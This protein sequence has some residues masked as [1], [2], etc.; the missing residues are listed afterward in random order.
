MNLKK[1]ELIRSGSVFFVATHM[2][3]VPRERFSLVE[4]EKFCLANIYGLCKSTNLK[5]KIRENI[6]LLENDE[7]WWFHN[8]HAY[9]KMP[10][11]RLNA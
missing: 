10:M 3:L 1:T 6:K 5:R 11:K 9:Y 2:T 4:I 7:K 8:Q